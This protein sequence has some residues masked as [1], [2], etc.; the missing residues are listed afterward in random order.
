MTQVFQQWRERKHSLTRT[1]NRVN[2]K[3]KKRCLGGQVDLKCVGLTVDSE[4]DC[5]R[6]LEKPST[7]K[8][9]AVPVATNCSFSVVG[10]I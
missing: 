10:G 3:S 7:N 4:H 8:K 9:A 5:Q 6:V 1:K 2:V